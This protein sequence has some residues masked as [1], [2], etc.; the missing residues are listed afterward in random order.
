MEN[1]RL[2]KSLLKNATVKQTKFA[3]LEV[4][5]RHH[6]AKSFH[7]RKTAEVN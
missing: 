7:V 1:D 6:A 2:L 5:D 3:S 4:L